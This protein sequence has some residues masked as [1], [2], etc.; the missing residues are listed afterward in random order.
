MKQEKLFIIIGLGIIVVFGFLI[1]AFVMWKP[2]EIRYYQNRLNSQEQKEV[3]NAVTK[4]LSMGHAGRAALASTSGAS[5]REISFLEHCWRDV[6]MKIHENINIE[7]EL[8][9][10]MPV[11]PLEYAA[12]MDYFRIIPLL[13]AQGADLNAHLSSEASTP[14]HYAVKNSKE[15]VV[16]ALIKS[17]AKLSITNRRYE[18][19]LHISAGA[20]NIR[21]AA[22]LTKAGAKVNY[23]SKGTSKHNPGTPLHVAVERNRLQMVEFLL[24]HDANIKQKNNLGYTVMRYAFEN[25]DKKMIVYL[26]EN[27]AVV[28]E[29]DLEDDSLLEFIMDDKIR[30]LIDRQKVK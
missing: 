26:L 9:I 30:G 28:C 2:L 8:D 15:Q 24:S 22:L 27:G 7:L 29:E 12:R 19:P 13:A 6:N 14:L 4:L 10:P 23:I 11:Y 5:D 1:L 16:M 20:G 17:G 18:T 3:A 21:I 25:G